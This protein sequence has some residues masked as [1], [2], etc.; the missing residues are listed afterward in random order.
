MLKPHHL[1]PNLNLR[2]WG[3]VIFFF[4]FL[5]R[6]APSPLEPP[7]LRALHPSGGRAGKDTSLRPV[8]TAIPGPSGDPLSLLSF[9]AFSGPTPLGRDRQRASPPQ[10]PGGWVEFAAR[11]QQ[12]V[13]PPP[14]PKLWGGAAW[15]SRTDRR[16]SPGWGVW[17]PRQG[18]VGG[19]AAPRPPV[20]WAPPPSAR[21]AL[22]LREL[23]FRPGGPASSA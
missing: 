9:S 11:R 7:P 2:R 19:T 6:S 14:P 16:T 10:P 3:P 15:R 4:F 8:Q 1:S 13:G 18:P 23:F 5:S 21:D 12:R 22:P 17:L 20:P